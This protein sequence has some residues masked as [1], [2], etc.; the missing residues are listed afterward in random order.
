MKQK[1]GIIEVIVALTGLYILMGW[2]V[3]AGVAI[4]FFLLV[5]SAGSFSNFKFFFYIFFHNLFFLK[6]FWMDLWEIERKY[7]QSN[8]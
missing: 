8:R 4:L 1:V 2:T 3:V 7:A 5:L 6:S